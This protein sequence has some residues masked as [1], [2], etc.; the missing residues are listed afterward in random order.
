F[1]SACFKLILGALIESST[2]LE[3]LSMLS[4]NDFLYS[5]YCVIISHY[6]FNLPVLC[7]DNLT[8]AFSNTR[9]LI[10]YI[11]PT[12]HGNSRIR[13]WEHSI[14]QFISTCSA[15]KSFSLPLD[16]TLTR[17]IHTVDI[18]RS[19]ARSTVLPQPRTFEPS[20]SMSDLGDLEDFTLQHSNT[21]L[22]I[23]LA[24]TRVLNGTWYLLLRSFR[25][26]MD[27]AKLHLVAPGQYEDRVTFP[28]SH[29]NDF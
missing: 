19:L 28:S 24:Y 27:L 20:G 10:L 11:I 17:S 18:I 7:L 16:A 23:T 25:E 1:A 2:E 14:S 15:L 4:G 12:Y 13:G 22:S 29:F 3:K 8:G 21:L 26:S 9:S 5:S 6:N